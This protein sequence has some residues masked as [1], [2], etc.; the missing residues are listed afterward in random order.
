MTKVAKTTKSTI[1]KK[2]KSSKMYLLDTSV[3]LDDPVNIE[4]IAQGGEN[5]IF[6]TDVVLSELNKKKELS[7]EAGYFARQFFRLINGENGEEVKKQIRSGMDIIQ[8]DHIRK[9]ILKFPAEYLKIGRA[10]V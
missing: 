4:Y 10:H 7:T 5:M 9:M 1:S 6:I 8:G 2:L 3:I